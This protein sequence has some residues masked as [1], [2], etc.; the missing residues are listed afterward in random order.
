MVN[1]KLTLRT[2]FS[3]PRLGGIVGGETMQINREVLE[4]TCKNTIEAILCCL[5]CATKGTIYQIGPMPRLQ[6]ERVT[7]GIRNN[8]HIEWGLPEDSDYNPPGKEWENYR[9]TPGHLLEA[10]GWCVEQQKSWT[11]DNPQE[12]IR[13]IRKQLKGEVEDLHHMEPVLVRKTDLYG[14]DLYD[15]E[16]PM[17]HTG[18]NL[19]QETEYIVVAVIKIHFLPS[20]VQ[21]GDRSTRVINKLS[22]TLGTEL[23]SLHLRETCLITREKMARERLQVSNAVAHELRNTLAKLGFVFSTI[24]TMMSFLRDQWELEFQKAY[25]CLQNKS[26]IL[27]RLSELLTMGR[28]R[29][30]GQKELVRLSDELLTEQ[31]E[32]KA[33]FL[34]PQQ[35]EMWLQKKIRPKWDIL[36]SESGVWNGSGEEVLQL[37]ERLEKAIWIVLDKELAA[38]IE[39]LPEE[40]KTSWPEIAYTQ[41]SANN[42]GSLDGA[43]NLLDHPELKIQHKPQLR[44]ALSSLKVVA[45]TIATVED[46]TNR[47]LMSL[48]NGDSN[49]PAMAN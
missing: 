15:L 29:L 17:D 31:E 45:E 38:N 47:V 32:L 40:L 23:L 16:Y 34:L 42:R 8:G 14:G 7:S 28:L 12:D 4:R 35:E 26:T 5:E 22:T 39:H 1:R 6:A 41:L 9:D 18:K 36:L 25:P 43:L 46:Q 21:R 11:A 19:W 20:S 24:N 49:H 10:M 48:K 13:S 30:N 3:F 37:I 44:K 33:M 27:E 2:R